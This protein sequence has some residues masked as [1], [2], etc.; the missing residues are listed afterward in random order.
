M[1]ILYLVSSD[2]HKEFRIASSGF[3]PD[4]GNIKKLESA[5]IAMLEEM[6]K[7]YLNLAC[8]RADK[9]AYEFVKGF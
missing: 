7:G 2:D 5:D 9:P 8:C 1:G 6:K 3:L 4:K